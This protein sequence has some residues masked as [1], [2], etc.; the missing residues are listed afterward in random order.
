M[1]TTDVRV[2]VRVDTSIAVR[3]GKRYLA[4]TPCQPRPKVPRLKATQ[5]R[6][7]KLAEPRPKSKWMDNFRLTS[8]EKT[9]LSAIPAVTQVQDV[10]PIR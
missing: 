8:P 10:K 3:F 5:R 9:A 4:V 2:E 7:R 1:R 6:T